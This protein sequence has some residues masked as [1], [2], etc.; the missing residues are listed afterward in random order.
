METARTGTWQ[1]FVLAALLGCGGGEG[2]SESS[3]SAD[4]QVS[5][6]DVTE[7]ARTLRPQEGTE[8]DWEIFRAKVTLARENGLDTIPIGEAMVQIGLSF[9]GTPYGER[10]LEVA[11]EEGVVVN[12]QELDCV[13]FVENAFALARFIRLTDPAL[14]DDAA[15]ARDRYRGF[16]REI[17]YRRA[18]VDGYPSRLHYFSDWIRDNEAKGLVRE[19][20]E[21]LGGAEDFDA[22]D[23]MTN[24]TEA[25]RQLANRANVEAIRTTEQELSALTRFKIAEEDVAEKATS[26]LNGDIIAATSTV[27]GLDIA[28][29]GLALWQDGRLHLLH[30]PLVGGVVEVSRLPLSD[31]ILRLQG[32]D[33]IRVARPLEVTPTSDSFFHP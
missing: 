24:H 20:T 18:T 30:A 15:A 2:G 23:F 7:A 16:L 17:R 32:Q 3:V 8:R 31:R 4:E 28:H 12:L 9:L 13:T 29:T 6:D 5:E 21:D 19:M 25:Y 26:I 27:E 10:T 14:M 33:G 11:G 22:I 1:V